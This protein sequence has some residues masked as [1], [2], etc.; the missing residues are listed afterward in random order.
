MRK[1]VIF[2]AGF[3][4]SIGAISQSV[5]TLHDGIALGDSAKLSWYGGFSAFRFL[6][7]GETNL[8]LYFNNKNNYTFSSINNTVAQTDFLSNG[9][10]TIGTGNAF[11]SRRNSLVIPKNNNDTTAVI[12]SIGS[13]YAMLDF[14]ASSSSATATLPGQSLGNIYGEQGD[15]LFNTPSSMNI[16]ATERLN[17][18]HNN[19]FRVWEGNTLRLH[20]VGDKIGINPLPIL[21]TYFPPAANLDV[22]GN[23]RS[24]A[25]SGTGKRVL[26]ANENGFI[27]ARTKEVK[28]YGCDHFLTGDDSYNIVIVDLSN[29]VYMNSVSS[30]EYL[31]LPIN[32]PNGVNITNIKI[33]YKDEHFTK[34][35]KVRFIARSQIDVGRTVNSATYNVSNA[36]F[37][38]SEISVNQIVNNDFFTY[39]LFF[40]VVETNGSDSTWPGQF[41]AIRS[42]TI[43]YEY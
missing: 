30:G 5:T 1:F 38:E 27:E 22:T 28:G 21:G 36:S 42:V 8:G 14:R 3:F 35:L 40:N 37:L 39:S 25:L 10:F 43:T 29:Y 33:R 26:V 4:F 41:I 31:R 16:K 12:Q 13:P 20:Q 32:L 24:T 6:S 19:S 9:R 11:A 23:I 7:T 15:A 34:G 18:K 2:L 17:F